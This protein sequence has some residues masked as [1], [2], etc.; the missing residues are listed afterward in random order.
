MISLLKLIRPVNLI[1]LAVTQYFIDIFLLQPVFNK[2][3][4]I[5]TL[6]EFEFFLLVLSTALI[7]GAGYI[8]NDYFDVKADA[9][10]K[11]AKLII[12]K[13]VTPAFAFNMYMLLTGMG[14]AIGIYLSI[15][16]GNW[17]LVTIHVISVF[18]LFAY[19]SSFKKVPLLGNIIVALLIAVSIIMVGVFEPHL[20]F[21]ARA[22][23][24]YAAD[25]CWHIIFSLSVFAFLLTMVREIV[26]DL[27]DMQGDKEIFARTMPIAWGINFS[28]A[29]AAFFI[30]TTIG[31]AAYTLSELNSASKNIYFILLFVLA[32]LL[33]Y[34]LVKLFSAKQKKDYS[35]LSLLLKI[36]M[37]TGICFLPLYFLL[38]Y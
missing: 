14:I 7:C 6:S 19:S 16:A 20:Y 12:G 34:C 37:L 27:E 33:M 36:C 22:G 2:Y 24:Y 28:K 31:V 26:K 9:V 25:L 38:E 18:L 8:I 21:L 23:D 11:P 4:M 29:M 10:N 13:S 17:K 3:G 35:T 1:I 30:L 15:A 32:A 5:F